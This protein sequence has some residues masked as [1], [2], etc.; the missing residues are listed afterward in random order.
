MFFS[1][2][3]GRGSVFFLVP[4]ISHTIG[5]QVLPT[6]LGHTCNNNR[7]KVRIDSNVTVDKKK[8]NHTPCSCSNCPWIIFQHNF[9]ILPLSHKYVVSCY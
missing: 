4:T 2:G 5:L 3:G 7:H 6:V 9:H 8:K 1:W